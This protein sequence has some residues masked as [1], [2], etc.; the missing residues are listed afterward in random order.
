LD[1]RV[2]AFD[3]QGVSYRYFQGGQFNG[4]LQLLLNEAF[5][6][7]IVREQ[8]EERVDVLLVGLEGGVFRELPFVHIL[9]KI[10]DDADVDIEVV[11]DILVGEEEVCLC[12]FLLSFHQFGEIDEESQLVFLPVDIFLEGLYLCEEAIGAGEEEGIGLHSHDLVLLHLVVDQFLHHQFVVVDYLSNCHIYFHLFENLTFLANLLD[13][14][15]VVDDLS[16]VVAGYRDVLEINQHL[17]NGDVL[18]TAQLQLHLHRLHQ[19]RVH[20]LVGRVEL[21]LLVVDPVQQVFQVRHFRHVGSEIVEQTQIEHL[22]PILRSFFVEGLNL[23]QNAVLFDFLILEQQ[24]EDVIVLEGEELRKGNARVLDSLT[25]LLVIL[26]Q[27][28]M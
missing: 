18:G 12:Y 2:Q 28:G 7:V 13:G 17:V 11:V 23:F 25:V 1:P 26:I 8:V 6:V 9:D 22:P 21:L 16:V 14:L 27:F 15:Q 19:H 20:A 10:F 5:K 3:G 4:K 24:F